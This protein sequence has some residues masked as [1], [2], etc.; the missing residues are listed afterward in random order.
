MAIKIEA[1]HQD[2]IRLKALINAVDSVLEGG[3]CPS[4][5]EVLI[6]VQ[7]M[8]GDALIQEVE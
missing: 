5:R 7:K 2:L 4:E 1:T 6:K 8:L 3:D